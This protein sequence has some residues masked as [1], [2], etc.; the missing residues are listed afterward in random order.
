MKK[1]ST[2]R[3]S[4][5][6]VMAVMG[7]MSTGHSNYTSNNLS[8]VR[9]KDAINKMPGAPRLM[10]QERRSGGHSGYRHYRKADRNQ[11]QYRKWMRQVP[12]FRNSKKCKL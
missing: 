3:K 1:I 5:A 8:A 12:Q 4:L 10:E 2:G 6:M 9:T 11:R 7:L